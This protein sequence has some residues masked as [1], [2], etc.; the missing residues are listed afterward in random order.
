MK[1]LFRVRRLAGPARDGSGQA[2]VEWAIV[3]PMLFIMLFS[4]VFFGIYFRDTSIL[5]DAARQGA[6]TVATGQGDGYGAVYTDLTAAG[7]PA[8]APNVQVTL[9]PSGTDEVCVVRYSDPLLPMFTGLVPALKPLQ[10]V[11]EK[12]VFYIEQ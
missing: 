7:I 11:T 4:M 5:L 10:T 12:A 9:E 6:R 1:R 2:L 3:A 8:P